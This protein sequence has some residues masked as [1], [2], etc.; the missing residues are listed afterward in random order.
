MLKWAFGLIGAGLLLVVYW[1]FNPYEVDFLPRCPFHA[2]TGFTCP[3][4]GSQRSLHY[5][6]HLEVAEAL[7]ENALLVL[8]LPYLLTYGLFRLAG[9]DR[10]KPSLRKALFGPRAIKVI[11]LVIVLFWI[12][13]N[14]WASSRG[15]GIQPDPPKAA[16]RLQTRKSNWWAGG[17]HA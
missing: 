15:G 16:F 13:R 11:M 8:S 5:L 2:F 4:C 1:Q 12:G 3:G 10:Q 14:G 7:R 6:L 17:E 9:W